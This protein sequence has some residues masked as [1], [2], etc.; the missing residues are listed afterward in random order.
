MEIWIRHEPGQEIDYWKTELC[1]LKNTWPS[2]VAG[3]H[4]LLKTLSGQLRRGILDL[5][6][7]CLRKNKPSGSDRGNDNV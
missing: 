3:K 6:G 5:F 4:G 1:H 2:S 7:C